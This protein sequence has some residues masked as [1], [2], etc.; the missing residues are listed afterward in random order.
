[1]LPLVGL[2][3]ALVGLP[4]AAIAMRTRADV[5]AIVTIT[6]LFVVQTLAFNLRGLTGGAQGLA[7]PIRRRSRRRPSSGPSTRCCWCCSPSPW[8]SPGPRCAARSGC[9]WRP[10]A[11]TR[12]RPRGIGV[13]VH[14]RQAAGVLRQRRPHRDGRRGLGLLRGLHLPA[15]RGRPADH[16]RDRADD[17]PRRPGDA[18]G[19]GLGAFLL[20]LGPAVPRLHA[21]RQPALPDRLRAG[22]PARDAAAAARHR[23]DGPGPAPATPPAAWPATRPPAAGHRPAAPRWPRDGTGGT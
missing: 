16:H 6:L 13:R 11:P 7:M 2:S 18:V 15:V 21:R 22:L 1:M 19:A 12:T 9:R 5:F 3:A 10:S 4:I 23:A 8:R 17:V 14:R 20:E